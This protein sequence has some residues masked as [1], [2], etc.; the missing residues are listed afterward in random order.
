MISTVTATTVTTV[1]TTTV[2]GLVVAL[3]L[4]AVLVLIGLLVVKELV[5]ASQNPRA[6][7]LA[8]TLNVGISPLLFVF[9]LIV[10]TRVLEILG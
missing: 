5:G 3:G 9:S 2:V 1:T 7:F 4:A 8:T 6:R 10:V